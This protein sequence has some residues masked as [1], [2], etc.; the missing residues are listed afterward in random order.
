M[1]NK[2]IKSGKNLKTNIIILNELI[3]YILFY[4][5]LKIRYLGDI[6]SFVP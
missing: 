4:L 2:M 6:K 1:I 5:G 3:V